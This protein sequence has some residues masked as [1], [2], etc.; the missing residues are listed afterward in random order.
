[1]FAES[2]LNFFLYHIKK[3]KDFVLNLKKVKPRL[4]VVKEYLKHFQAFFNKTFT[5]I[6]EFLFWLTQG[7]QKWTA[8]TFFWS[9]QKTSSH[10]LK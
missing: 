10:V 5:K 8:C 1:M 6:N 9:R 4:T 2:L 7:V 3:V